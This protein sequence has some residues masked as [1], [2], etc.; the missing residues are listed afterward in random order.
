MTH[1]N[2]QNMIAIRSFQNLQPTIM[3]NY[4]YARKS[5]TFYSI[6]L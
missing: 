2:Y 4:V 1:K 6:L 3:P 5:I